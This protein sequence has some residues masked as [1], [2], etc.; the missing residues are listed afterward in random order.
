MW[1]MDRVQREEERARKERRD[2]KENRA[3]W[4][5]M[6]RHFT[7]LATRDLC[8]LPQA[9]KEERGSEAKEEGKRELKHIS[10]TPWDSPAAQN[11]LFRNEMGEHRRHRRWKKR[12]H[13]PIRSA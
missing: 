11:S 4:E 13:T 10:S 6:S 7:R 5:E 12:P 3:P 8:A 9:K 2:R 1:E